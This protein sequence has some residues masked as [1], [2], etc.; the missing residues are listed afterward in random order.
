MNIG[1]S[2]AF[3]DLVD[4]TSYGATTASQALGVSIP[5]DYSEASVGSIKPESGLNM[6]LGGLLYTLGP[7]RLTDEQWAQITFVGSATSFISGASLS[8]EVEY[9]IDRS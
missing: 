2:G 5:I 3:K 7:L 6:A 1:F 9:Y 4:R 8:L